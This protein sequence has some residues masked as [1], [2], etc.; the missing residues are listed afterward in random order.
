MACQ[1]IE[2]ALTVNKGQSLTHGHRGDFSVSYDD[3][4]KVRFTPLFFCKF[5]AACH[6]KGRFGKVINIRVDL[7]TKVRKLCGQLDE[8]RLPCFLPCSR[9]RRIGENGNQEAAGFAVKRQI[10]R[11]RFTFARKFTVKTVS[12]RHALTGV[13]AGVYSGL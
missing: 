8:R 13:I 3:R 2:H 9:I 10:D 7:A 5:Q 11:A 12:V 4:T 1:R 6:I